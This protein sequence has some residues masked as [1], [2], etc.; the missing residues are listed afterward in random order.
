MAWLS[1]WSYRVKVTVDNTKVSANLSDFPIYLDLSGLPA[2]FHS[3]VRSDGG[4]IR[5]TTSDGETEV[6][7]EVVWYDADTDTGEVHFKGTLSSSED[8]DFYIYYGKADANDYADDDTYGAENVWDSNY[9]AVHH[10]ED[11]TTSTVKDSTSTGNDGAKA[12][13]NNPEETSGFIGKGQDFGTDDYIEL[14]T[15]GMPNTN[16]SMTLSCWA[17]Y[18]SGTP[19]T[20]NLVLIDNES[21]AALQLGF[22]GSAVSVWLW[23]AGIILTTTLPGGGDWH[24]YVVT[25]DGSNHTLYLD[26][27][28]V[29]TDTTTLQSGSG[30]E[31]RINTDSW[32]ETFIGK[33]DEARISNTNRSSDW[34]STEYNNQN[35]PSTFY[36][37]GEEETSQQN[38]QE[39]ATETMLLSDSVNVVFTQADKWRIERQT[40]G[41]EWE[42]VEASIKI[43]EGEGEFTYDDEDDFE[44]GTEYCYRVKH[45]PDDSRWSNTDCAT[46]SSGVENFQETILDSLSMAS[47]LQKKTGFGL[48]KT[49]SVGVKTPTPL[50]KGAFYKILSDTVNLVDSIVVQRLGIFKE[51][52]ID[53]ISLATSILKKVS[54]KKLLSDSVALQSLV[55]SLKKF[56]VVA[57]DT[58]YLITKKIIEEFQV[59]ITDSIKLVESVSATILGI[60]KEIITDTISLTTSVIKKISFKKIV[61]D[62]VSLIDSVIATAIR[63]FEA[64]ISDTISLTASIVKKVSFKKIATSTI[65]L[66]DTVIVDLLGKFKETILDTISL[67]GDISKKVSFKKV[68]TDTLTLVK[69]VIVTAKENFKELISDTMSLVSSVSKKVEFKKIL[70][71]EIKLSSIVSIFSTAWTELKKS[72]KGAWTHIAKSTPGTW[73]NQTKNK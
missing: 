62:T 30:I 10:L 38:I 31:A 3:N 41:G 8:T 36:E 34:V 40:D 55:T 45:V 37:V 27:S 50:T 43:D 56:Y 14:G 21:N 16:A 26:G 48:T 59:L 29:D 24:Y 54:F 22:R 72:A 52:I 25:T 64:I 7:R 5:I 61:T 23:G 11:V 65:R 49:E 35:S 20:E 6:P 2:G 18:P 73:S 47:T 1:G 4:D 28:S 68:A 39:T 13:A 33:I 63:R 66:I 17:Y 32:G 9:K 42:V 19:G 58:V 67:V 69:S 15:T 51:T 71:T 70:T 57:T 53:T 12:S 60:F 44:N 46:F